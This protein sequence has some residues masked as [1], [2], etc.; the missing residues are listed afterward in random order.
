MRKGRKEGRRKEV[1]SASGGREG[2]RQRKR[3]N[4]RNGNSKKEW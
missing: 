1:G 2:R 3:G 4:Y